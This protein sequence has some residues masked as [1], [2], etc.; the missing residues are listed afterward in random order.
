MKSALSTGPCSALCRSSGETVSDMGVP[1]L[2]SGRSVTLVHGAW[3]VTGPGG[4]TWLPPAPYENSYHSRLA[5]PVRG[6]PRGNVDAAAPA[7]PKPANLGAAVPRRRRRPRL[8]SHTARIGR[9]E[10]R[11][12]PLQRRL[13]RTP[14]RPPAQDRKS[15]V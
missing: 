6:N 3:T 13:R 9:R 12:R 5:P 10:T 8:P 1:L 7:E 4:H 11:D 15:V 14:H 2:C